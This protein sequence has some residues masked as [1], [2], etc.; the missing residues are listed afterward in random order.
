MSLDEFH[1]VPVFHPFR[2]DRKTWELQYDANKREDVIVSKPFPSNDLFD[3]ELRIGRKRSLRAFTSK[4]LTFCTF[5]YAAGVTFR[6][7]IA[8]GSALIVAL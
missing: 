3:E 1:D 2:Y 4:Q 8:T 7:F 6:V 5:L